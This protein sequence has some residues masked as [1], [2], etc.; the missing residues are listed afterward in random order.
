MSIYK[1]REKVVHLAADLSQ[2]PFGDIVG[3]R[4]FLGISTFHL[5]CYLL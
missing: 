2:L 3:Y 4:I 1:Q 5:E